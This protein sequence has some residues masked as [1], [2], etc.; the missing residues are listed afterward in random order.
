M[1]LVIDGTTHRLPRAWGSEDFDGVLD[2]LRAA[3]I[4]TWVELNIGPKQRIAFLY[5][6][7]TQIQ[8]SWKAPADSKRA[9]SVIMR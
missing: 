3:Q 8:I 2:T 6:E 4:D 5:R 9:G 7:N 1:E